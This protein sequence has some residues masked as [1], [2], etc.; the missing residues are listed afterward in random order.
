[1]EFFSK[2]VQCQSSHSKQLLMLQIFRHSMLCQY[3]WLGRLGFRFRLWA[4][5][6]VVHGDHT[7][8]HWLSDLLYLYLGVLDRSVK[9]DIMSQTDTGQDTRHG[10][11][12][13]SR[14]N[15]H[16]Q[17]LCIHPHQ[18]LEKAMIWNAVVSHT[19]VNGLCSLHLSL[20]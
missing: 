11:Y 14:L 15:S 2:K 3:V 7:G 20:L 8:H 13:L 16:Y 1:M 12:L 17:M 10:Q 18:V 19:V 5:V 6:S 9:L 4:G